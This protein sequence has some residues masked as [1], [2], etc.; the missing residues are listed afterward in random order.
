MTI[1]RRIESSKL[2]RLELYRANNCHYKA[3]HRPQTI[4]NG[5]RSHRSTKPSAMY[6]EA[7]RATNHQFQLL[8]KESRVKRADCCKLTQVGKLTFR[9]SHLSVCLPALRRFLS[10]GG[11]RLK[12]CVTFAA[13]WSRGSTQ[14]AH[15]WT[16]SSQTHSPP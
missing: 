8:P 3:M 10:L 16:P 14:E 15:R 2:V 1:F 12:C 4:P 6:C 5:K 9:G 11:V 7:R 13:R